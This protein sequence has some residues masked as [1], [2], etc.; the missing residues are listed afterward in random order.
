MIPSRLLT[1]FVFLAAATSVFA[2]N[3]DLLHPSPGPPA[4]E[5]GGS[6]SVKP[7]MTGGSGTNFSDTLRRRSDAPRYDPD[8]TMGMNAAQHNRLALYFS[9]QYQ[10]QN[11]ADTN[12]LVNLAR[13]LTATS[14][15]SGNLP[16]GAE[17]KKVQEIEKL[18]RRV[19]QRLTLP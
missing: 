13:E 15:R 8:L 14:E 16:T 6:S 11:V 1:Q 10:R 19:R 9:A 2:Q 17:M 5:P 18:A 3:H 4:S 12:R 7:T